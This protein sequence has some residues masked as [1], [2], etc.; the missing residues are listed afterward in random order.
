MRCSYRR[1]G[2]RGP[3]AYPNLTDAISELHEAIGVA[4]YAPVSQSLVRQFA[5]DH[6]GI[7]LDHLIGDEEDAADGPGISEEE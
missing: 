1:A 2:R 3:L 7:D 5:R 4:P 6:L